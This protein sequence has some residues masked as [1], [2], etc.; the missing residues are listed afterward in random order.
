MARYI[1]DHT[2]ISNDET[3]PDNMSAHVQMVCAFS[4]KSETQSTTFN[5]LCVTPVSY[6]RYFT[7]SKVSLDMYSAYNLCCEL[8]QVPSVSGSLSVFFPVLWPPRPQC[9]TSEDYMERKNGHMETDT[10][11]EQWP[12]GD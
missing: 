9:Y 5:I 1:L 11:S 4:D 2:E 12:H 7:H 3:Q 6:Y 8:T 10:E